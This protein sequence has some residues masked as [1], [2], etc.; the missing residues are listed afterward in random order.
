MV[1]ISMWLRLSTNLELK[2]AEIVCT[3]DDDRD[4]WHH[5]N[6]K[7]NGYY[8]RLSCA[9]PRVYNDHDNFE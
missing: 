9:Q 6:I 4:K 2:A 1:Q 3:R 5:R 8:R 7:W